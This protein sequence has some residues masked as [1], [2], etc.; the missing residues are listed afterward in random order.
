MTR[1][2]E[3]IR[4]GLLG[5]FVSAGSPLGL[6]ACA[7][8]MVHKA[9]VICRAVS[10]ASVDWHILCKT[11][12]QTNKRPKKAQTSVARHWFY[13]SEMEVPETNIPNVILMDKAVTHVL[14]CVAQG[15]SPCYPEYISCLPGRSL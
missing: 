9:A 15:R 3:V 6:W 8:F 7:V 12:K 4:G 13:M 14:V 11:N 10:S 2:A 5:E 1:T